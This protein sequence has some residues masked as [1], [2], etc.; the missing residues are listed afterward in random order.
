[1]IETN[2]SKVKGLKLTFNYLYLIVAEQMD[3]KRNF[4]LICYHYKRF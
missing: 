2:E 3:K 1:M 4:N